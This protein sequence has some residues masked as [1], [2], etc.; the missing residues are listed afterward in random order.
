MATL[1]EALRELYGREVNVSITSF[2][3]AGWTVQI[4]DGWNGYRAERQFRSEEFGLIGDWL[5][6]HADDPEPAP[7]VQPPVLETT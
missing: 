4:G 2:W 7:L 3:D 1:E 5:L 6:A